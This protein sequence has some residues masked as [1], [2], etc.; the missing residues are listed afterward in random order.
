MSW[1]GAGLEA[2]MKDKMSNKELNQFR[3]EVFEE[4]H[5]KG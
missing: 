4:K 2:Y 1:S 3:K 5:R